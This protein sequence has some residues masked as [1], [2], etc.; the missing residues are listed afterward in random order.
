[1]S[2]RLDTEQGHDKGGVFQG[3][4]SLGR[5]CPEIYKVL[6]L[7]SKPKFQFQFATDCLGALSQPRPISW[8]QF[9]HL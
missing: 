2:R 5:V 9:P 3:S 6:V 7:E 8:L 4:E 1:M